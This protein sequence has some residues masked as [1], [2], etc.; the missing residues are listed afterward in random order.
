M[1]LDTVRFAAIVEWAQSVVNS[2][3]DDS[4]N[5]GKSYSAPTITTSSAANRIYFTSQTIAAA[6]T[7][8]LNCQSLTDALGQAIVATRIYGIW[9]HTTGAALRME[10]DA[11][12]GLVFPFDDASDKLTIKTEGHFMCVANTAT[13]VDATHKNITFTN[14]SG[15]VSTAVKILLLLGQ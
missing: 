3:F 4:K 5:S 2:G 9:F 7:L 8:T 11:S 14:T 12:N 15:S 10:P 1:A 6:G 13:T